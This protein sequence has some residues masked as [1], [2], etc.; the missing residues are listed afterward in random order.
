MHKRVRLSIRTH[1]P[2]HANKLG[3]KKAHTL[4]Y[5]QPH[6][7][8]TRSRAHANHARKMA[9]VLFAMRTLSRSFAPPLNSSVECR[10]NRVA[11]RAAAAGTT[12]QSS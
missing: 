7:A 5:K 3:H 9:V 1:A 10:Y 2:V 11:E 12:E 6:Q 8:R 4:M